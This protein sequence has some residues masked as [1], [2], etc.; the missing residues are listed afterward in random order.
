MISGNLELLK[1]ASIADKVYSLTETHFEIIFELEGRSGKMT[2]AGFLTPCREGSQILKA[3][4][5]PV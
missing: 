2:E 5:I 1:L 4:A 3:S